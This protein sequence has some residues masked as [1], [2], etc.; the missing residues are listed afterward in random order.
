[1]NDTQT[2]LIKAIH[3]DAL[4]LTKNNA[5]AVLALWLALR[6]FLGRISRPDEELLADV[7]AVKQWL[8]L[9]IR[10]GTGAP[11]EVTDEELLAAIA[12]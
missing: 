11:D 2:L 1:M 12:T 7:A 5:D 4:E 8:A 3:A 9:A 10:K 6:D